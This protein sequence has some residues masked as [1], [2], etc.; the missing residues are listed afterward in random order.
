MPTVCVVKAWSRVSD[1]PRQGSFSF[2]GFASSWFC[3]SLTPESSVVP[4]EFEEPPKDRDNPPDWFE[5]LLAPS[6]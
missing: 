2:F 5:L 6:A 3:S 4:D 1:V